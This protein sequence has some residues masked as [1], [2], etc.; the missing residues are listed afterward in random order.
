[1]QLLK[2]K[3]MLCSKDRIESRGGKVNYVTCLLILSF[4]VGIAALLL[5]SVAFSRVRSWDP[6][7]LAITNN[8]A[9]KTPPNS[10]ST[11]PALPQQAPPMR[12]S[13]TGDQAALYILS[14]YSESSCFGGAGMYD[15]M[16]DAFKLGLRTNPISIY[17]SQS[18][19]SP[20][21]H[22]SSLA[23]LSASFRYLSFRQFSRNDCTGSYQDHVRMIIVSSST[24]ASS[25]CLPAPFFAPYAQL[26]FRIAIANPDFDALNYAL[27]IHSEESMDYDPLLGKVWFGSRSFQEVFT[28]DAARSARAARPPSFGGVGYPALETF[29]LNMDGFTGTFAVPSNPL[30]FFGLGTFGESVQKRY[31][32]W[33]WHST[34][35]PTGVKVDYSSSRHRIWFCRGRFLGSPLSTPFGGASVLD[36]SASFNSA[37]PVQVIC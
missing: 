30:H 7:S 26:Y 22:N 11:P 18:L 28:M 12:N 8:V 19:C 6:T 27:P 24:S 34:Q 31:F 16:V 15:P 20:I 25:Q 33:Y 2:F 17:S 23:I 4:S 29:S 37:S 5:G 9:P 36:F 1:V 3:T 13:A 32:G 14:F 35:G 10:V 21:A